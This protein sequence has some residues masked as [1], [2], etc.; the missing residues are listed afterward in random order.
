MPIS[1]RFSSLGRKI[2]SK[3]APWRYNWE[4]VPKSDLVL[5][6]IKPRLDYS[7]PS[8]FLDRS[9]NEY[10]PSIGEYRSVAPAYDVINMSIPLPG[11][12]PFPLASST[13]MDNSYY[14]PVPHSFELLDWYDT[15][16]EAAVDDS[17]VFTPPL[18]PGPV[19]ASTPIG[20]GGVP[21]YMSTPVGRHVPVVY[22]PNL[23]PIASP[24]SASVPYYTY[25][26]GDELFTYF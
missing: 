15:L 1:R 2:R 9:F 21:T 26:N 20:M 16:P 12:I 13:M 3:V 8:G 7:L 5:A 10:W 25:S 6:R 19:Y 4:L 17:S 11:V 22:F 18:G 14:Q 24:V 23:S